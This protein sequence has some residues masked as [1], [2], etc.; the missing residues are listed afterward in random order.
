M[1]QSYMVF[2]YCYLIVLSVVE[3]ILHSLKMMQKTNEAYVELH[4]YKFT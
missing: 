3:I 2:S 4:S 1:D